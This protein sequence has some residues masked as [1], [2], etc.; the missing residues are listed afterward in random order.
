M[1]LAQLIKIQLLRLY[2]TLK[3]TQ[4]STE[5]CVIKGGKGHGI[6]G[7]LVEIGCLF[8][9]KHK[10]TKS[11]DVNYIIWN[12]VFLVLLKLISWKYV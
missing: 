4:L 7:L 2:E 3:V 6:M 1:Y 5:Y 12:N 8:C 9:Y 10:F 11:K